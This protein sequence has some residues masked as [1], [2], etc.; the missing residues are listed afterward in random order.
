MKTMV[1]KKLTFED[2]ETVVAECKKNTIMGSCLSCGVDS[3]SECRSS[4]NEA[5]AKLSSVE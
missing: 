4:R 1:T 2:D 3:L 5:R